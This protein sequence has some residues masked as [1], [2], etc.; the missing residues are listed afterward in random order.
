MY[1]GNTCTIEKGQNSVDPSDWQINI[2]RK[3][4]LFFYDDVMQ[5]L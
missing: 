1:Y 2:C 3:K 5:S 4:I